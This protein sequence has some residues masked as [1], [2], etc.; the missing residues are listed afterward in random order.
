MTVGWYV[1]HHGSGHLRRFLAVR[2]HLGPEVVGMGSLP[3]PEGVAP[4]GWL[5]LPGDVPEGEP[6]DPT[7]GGTLHWVPRRV[8]GL[9]QRTAAIAAWV[10]RT[11]PDVLVV[12]VSAEVATLGRLL[13]VPTVVVGQRGIRTDPAHALAWAGASAVLLPWTAATD[14]PRDRPAGTT[15]VLCGAVSRF[16]A[17]A[18]PADAAASARA[19]GVRAPGAPT[20]DDGAPAVLG[21]LPRRVLLLVGGGG[22]ALHAE[23]ALAAADA[24]PGT[25]WDV[26]GALRVP[27]RPGLVDHGPRADVLPLLER[28]D[29]VVG[30]AGANVVAE[31]AAARRPLVL[32]P[33][34]RPF[35]EQRR[36]AAAL[37]PACPVV[38]ADGWPPPAAWPALLRE[39][40]ASPVA[41]WAAH[42]DGLG[43]RRMAAAVEAVADDRDPVGAARAVGA[44]PVGDARTVPGASS[45][46]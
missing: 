39:A 16:D 45:C 10:E 8:D 31:V 3:R 25:A 22:H 13:S 5:E 23:D 19:G 37:A 43:T 20:G 36:Q 35:D 40:A 6:D 14:A 7:A 32:L 34:A 2:E 27:A 15:A 1:H 42:H 26:A 12:D 44:A 38:V 24:T 21:A 9:R 18:A 17:R 29:V 41:A 11:R 4:S 28:A 30:T 46:A 33:Q